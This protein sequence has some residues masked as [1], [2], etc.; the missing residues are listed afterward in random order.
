M[1]GVDEVGVGPLAGAVTAAA[2]TAPQNFGVIISKLVG[3]LRDSKALTAR[4]REDFYKIF[5][6]LPEISYAIASVSEKIIDRINIYEARRLAAKRAVMKLE[7]KAGRNF[8]VVILDG[9]TYIN[10]ARNQIAVVKGDE[11]IA[12]CAIAS[13]IAKVTR[14]GMMIRAHRKYPEYRFDLHKGYGTKLHF[15]MIQ[16][17][18]VSPIHRRSFY[19]GV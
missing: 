12:L 7:K 16:K 18:G 6:E 10:I 11:K 14:D 15:N 8:D 17:Y 2:V 1:V 4:R 19:L 3:D 5:M 9:K 13:I